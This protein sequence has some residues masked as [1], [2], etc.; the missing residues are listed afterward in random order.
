MSFPNARVIFTRH[1]R[2]KAASHAP[3]V[4]III[5]KNNDDMED[6]EEVNKAI[7]NRFKIIAS[8]ANKVIKIWVRWET[9][10]SIVDIV[11]KT[12][13]DKGINDIAIRGT[14][15]LWFTRPRL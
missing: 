12:I 7:I 5:T 13:K 8:K 6:S 10:V 4:R 15:N 11:Q 14:L 1:A 9:M 2:P 3:K